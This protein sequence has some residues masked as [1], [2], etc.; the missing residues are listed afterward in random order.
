MLVAGALLPLVVVTA[1][2]IALYWRQ[3]SES[4]ELRYLERV[5]VMSVA[6]DTELDGFIRLLRALALTPELDMN[7]KQAFAARMRRF[8]DSQPTW[9]HFALGDPEWKDVLAVGHEGAT[10]A[11]PAIDP[12]AFMSISKSRAPTVSPLLRTA[13]NRYETQVTVPVIRDGA[14]I[15][16]LMVSVDQQAWLRLLG[17]YQLSSAATMTL[18][19]QDARIIARTLNNET[20]VGKQSSSRFRQ[21]LIET[22]EGTGRSTSLEGQPF[23]FAYSRGTRFG[24]TVATGVPVQEAEESVR[25]AAIIVA[26]SA[27]ATLLFVMLLALVFARRIAA[28]LGDA[29]AGSNP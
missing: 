12:R 6:V 25:K 24:W 23:Y 22:T 5:R 18:L 28:S 1:V 10:P 2:F 13:D 21:T 8:L 29:R 4:L 3:Q 11:R 19:D 20:W 16:I 17:Q 15:G 26:A 7:N 9:R 14:M 27:A